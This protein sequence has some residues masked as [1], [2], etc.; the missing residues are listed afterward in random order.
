MLPD[1]VVAGASRSGT[2]TLHNALKAHPQ[3][4][5]PR[6]KE[7]HFFNDD[8]NYLKGK[9]AYERNFRKLRPGQLAGEISP[10][11]FTRGI[12]KS[13]TGGHVWN[14][15]DDSAA[16]MARMI[17]DVRVIFSLRNPIDRAYSQYC[18]NF[19]EGKDPAR[20]FDEAIR[21]EL[22]GARTPQDSQ[23]C[24]L[25]K[26]LYS[27]HLEHWRSLFPES[28]LFYCVFEEWT[29][30][31]QPVFDA[32]HAFLGVAPRAITNDDLAIANS[33]RARRSGGF[34]RRFMPKKL[35]S[36]RLTRKDPSDKQEKMSPQ[37]RSRVRQ[38]FE[39]DIKKVEAITGRELGHWLG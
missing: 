11:Y 18:K 31:P 14:P 13:A 9:G 25:Y 15:Q 16:R 36:R 34:L 19:D 30:A 20:S 35:A 4:L 21:L 38:Y 23:S 39:A 10:P 2:T 12:T 8:K 29:A 1:F 22:E 26:N 28:Q 37:T 5:L 7:L 32:I 17:P 3:I 27:I 24:W 6:D 33:T